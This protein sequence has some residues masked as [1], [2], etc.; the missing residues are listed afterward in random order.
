MIV[1]FDKMIY[2]EQAIRTAIHDYQ[3]IAEIL[4]SV[5][6]FCFE[7]RIVQSIYPIDITALE[8]SNYVLN[9]SVSIRSEDSRHEIR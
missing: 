6:P 9:Q 4:L 5:G 2:K 7:C 8:F 3:Q 1:T